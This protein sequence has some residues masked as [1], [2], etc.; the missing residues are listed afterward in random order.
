MTF[1]EFLD[2]YLLNE[3]RSDEIGYLAQTRLFDQVKKL[4]NDILIPDYCALK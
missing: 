2:Q 4:K 3:N 1:N